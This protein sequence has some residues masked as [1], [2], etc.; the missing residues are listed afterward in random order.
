MH[1]EE[2]FTDLASLSRPLWIG[3][4]VERLIREWRP[5]YPVDGPSKT[6]LIGNRE[7]SFKKRADVQD[8]QDWHG[9]S[10]FIHN[11]EILTSS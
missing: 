11:H 6:F 10:S 8:L 9:K 3:D 4:D 5:E 1:V 7:L 2:G